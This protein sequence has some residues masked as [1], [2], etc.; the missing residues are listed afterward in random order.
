MAIA[1]TWLVIYITKTKRN[2]IAKLCVLATD[3]QTVDERNA[4]EN[5]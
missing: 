3:K 4:A 2:R 5:K 1:H